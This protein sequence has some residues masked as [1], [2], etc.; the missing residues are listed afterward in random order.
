[1]N[2]YILVEPKKIELTTAINNVEKFYFLCVNNNCFSDDLKYKSIDVMLE[3]EEVKTF[4]AAGCHT[5]EEVSYRKLTCD[6]FL[7]DAQQLLREMS[8]AVSKCF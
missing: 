3:I 1:M 7:N 2:T 6:K 4:M 5:M 8:I